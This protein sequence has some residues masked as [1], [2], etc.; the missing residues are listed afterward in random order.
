MNQKYLI[1]AATTIEIEPF[2]QH[3][4]LSAKTFIEHPEFDIIITG[5]GA[6][7]TTFNIAK[8]SQQQYRFLLNVGIA[9]SFD[10]NIPLGKVLNVSQDYFADFG[11]ESPDG[12]LSAE[13]LS[14]GQNYF[15]KD[16]QKLH[17]KPLTESII[18]QLPSVKG[19]TVQTVHGQSD[20][21]EKIQ[22]RINAQVESM[23]GAAVFFAGQALKIPVLQIRSI[24]N[25]V[26]PRQRANW[27]LAEAIKNLNEWLVKFVKSTNEY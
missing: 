14:L 4:D 24:S 21:I 15:P 11:A 18:S 10:R 12:F 6:W 3:H 2:L 23:E 26:E 13:S 7:A 1:I 5:V 25:Y 9:G 8:F 27:Q 19:I 22:S 17:L 16:E 20:S